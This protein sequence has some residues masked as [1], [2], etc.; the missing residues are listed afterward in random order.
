M[1]VSAPARA[2][3]AAFVRDRAAALDAA[4]TDVRADIAEIGARGLL[5]IDLGDNDIREFA[6]VVEEVAAESLAA[7]FSLWAQ[8]M[9]LEYVRRAP[10]SVQARYLDDLASG[11]LV[12]VTAMAAALKHLAGLGELPLRAD[13]GATRSVSGPIAWASNVFDDAL[14]VFP[15]RDR[16]GTGCVAVVAAG[17][18]GVRVRPAP[19]LLALGATGSTALIFDHVEVPDEQVVTTDLPLFGAVIRPIFLLLQTAFCSGIAGR[20]VA[21]AAGLLDGLGAPFR[22]EHTGLAA[23][24]D[25]VR[26]RLYDFAIDPGRVAPADL[27]RLRLDAS[28]IAVD[29]TRLES[30]LRG[31]AGFARGCDTNRR[32]REAAFLPVQ[33]PSEGQLRWEL[34]QYD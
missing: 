5:S 15:Y 21:E 30:T 1:T 17:A 24:Q 19:E 23:R 2:A 9:T 10:E 4:T 12:G 28:R 7:G 26:A 27:I 31:G 18:H 22:G 6:A 29:A 3:V 25:S 32:F 11:R 34:S 20:S 8:R 33:S 13:A 16:E 14:I